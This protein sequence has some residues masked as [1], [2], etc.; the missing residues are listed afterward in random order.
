LNFFCFVF[1][2]TNTCKELLLFFTHTNINNSTY[3]KSHANWGG[4]GIGE[5][6][7]GGR[8]EGGIIQHNNNGCTHQLYKGMS[9]W[10]N[11]HIHPCMEVIR[12]RKG[13]GEMVN[14]CG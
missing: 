1:L 11:D 8:G 9:A 10:R 6:R 13:G 12:E 2:D 5:R 14:S 4:K 3:S 7:G